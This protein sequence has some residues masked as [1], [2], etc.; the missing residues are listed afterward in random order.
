[1]SS[2]FS[3]FFF[4]LST[5]CLLKGTRGDGSNLEATKLGAMICGFSWSYLHIGQNFEV[6]P[7]S[8]KVPFLS[9]YKTRNQ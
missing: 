2:E 6:T 9:D 4:F 8:N 1:M 3:F 5:I 7:V